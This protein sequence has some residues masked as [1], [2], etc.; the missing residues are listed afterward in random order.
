MGSTHT[1]KKNTEAIVVASNETDLKE[2]A[3]N[4]KYM[5]IQGG[6]RNVIPFIVQITHFDYYKNI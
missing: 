2:N 5:I 3:E 4:T 6:A 1:I